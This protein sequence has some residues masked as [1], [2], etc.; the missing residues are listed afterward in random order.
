MVDFTPVHVGH[1]ERA[2]GSVREK[3]G[4]KPRVA[5]GEKLAAARQRIGAQRRALAAQ[6]LPLHEILRR[7]ADENIFAAHEHAARRGKRARVRRVHQVG[8]EIRR[9]ARAADRPHLRLGLHLRDLL[10]RLRK[11]EV[12][13]PPQL[14]R[15]EH[16]LQHRM[17]VRADEAPPEAV[18]AQ[19]ELPAPTR[20]FKHQR[21]GIEA[22]VGRREVYRRTLRVLGRNH[23]SAH[24]TRRDVDFSVEPEHRAAHAQ[25]RGLARIET[26]EHDAALIGNAV[27][28]VILEINNIRRAR[29]EDSAAPNRDAVGITQSGRELRALVE[30]PVAIGVLQQR[31]APQ[32]RRGLAVDRIGIAAPLDDV[33][34]AALV[35]RHRH[36]RDDERL[37]GDEL[38]ARAGFD[39][40]TRERLFRRKR[41]CAIA[42][43][44]GGHH[45]DCDRDG[46]QP[47]S[48]PPQIHGAAFISAHIR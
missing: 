26:R 45:A 21:V 39:L 30:A 4:A 31:D 18:E 1:V 3:H 42:R 34:P 41:L 27:A 5:R 29:D 6:R 25:L 17:A 23:F 16:D 19:P 46:G 8:N 9:H 40:E 44:R 14:P 20:R 43:G 35:E 10:H 2:V 37:G 38:D 11:R 28:I 33:E 36:R 12:R 32:A 24:E 13:V 48:E 22:S 47:S 7:L 15:L